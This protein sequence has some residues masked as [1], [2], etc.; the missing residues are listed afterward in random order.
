[1]VER[2]LGRGS[3]TE[4]E[5]VCVGVAVRVTLGKLVRGK[6]CEEEAWKEVGGSAEV[7]CCRLCVPCE[8]VWNAS[9][10]A[11]LVLKKSGIV[12]ILS[13]KDPPGSSEDRQG[14]IRGR[15]TLTGRF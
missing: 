10:L 14:E 13:C 6:T 11:R 15:E 12:M 5:R 7:N 8:G 2:I 1:M 9:R 3:N 4:E